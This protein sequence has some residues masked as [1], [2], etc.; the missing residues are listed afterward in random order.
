[1][2]ESSSPTLE[3]AM[4]SSEFARFGGGL[5]DAI[6]RVELTPPA[7][8]AKPFCGAVGENGDAKGDRRMDSVLDSAARGGSAML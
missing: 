1:M 5:G 6:P 8:R 7:A 4:R 3:G 2:L